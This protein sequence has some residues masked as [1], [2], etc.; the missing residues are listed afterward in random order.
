MRSYVLLMRSKLPP[1]N[2]AP[3][4]FSLSVTLALIIS[5]ILAGRDLLVFLRDL[6]LSFSSILAITLSVYIYNDLTDIEID[7]LN[8][9]NRPLVTGEA[10]KN[11]ARIL[12]MILGVAGLTISSII[13]LEVF[14][15]MLMFFV[16][17]FLYS[18]P[19]VRLKNRFLIKDLTIAAGT[20][21]TYL[22]GGAVVGSV[23]AP[24]FLMGSVGFASALSTSIVKDFRDV[25]GDEI[26]KV[27]TLPIVWGPLLTIRFAIALILSVGIA[28]VIGYY[29]LGF[30]IAFPILA[31]CAFA[32]WIYV[33]YPLLRHYDE[34]SYLANS[35]TLIRK[36]APIC[37]SIQILTIVGSVI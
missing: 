9:L 23:P 13:N 3:T 12:V 20:F 22:I 35:H 17:F 29:R 32:A 33:I 19:P 15:L 14:S 8:K 18:F 36:I 25:K 27:K 2:V 24:I 16:L 28:T 34:P 5:S 37:F 30:N 11:D 4:S 26:H 7:R 10:S 21:L 1:Y 31:S 6:V